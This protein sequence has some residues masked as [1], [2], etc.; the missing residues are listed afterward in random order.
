[1]GDVAEFRVDDTQKVG[2]AYGHL[3]QVKSGV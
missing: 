1:M 3:G 2:A